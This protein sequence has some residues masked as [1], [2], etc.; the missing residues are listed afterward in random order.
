MSDRMDAMEPPRRLSTIAFVRMGG[1]ISRHGNG[2]LDQIAVHKSFLAQ[3]PLSTLAC[4]RVAE[5]GP[6]GDEGVELAPLT[7]GID[8]R[9]EIR[10][11]SSVEIATGKAGIKL[12]RIDTDETRRESTGDELVCELRCVAAPDRKN[13]LE[14]RS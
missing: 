3:Q 6:I 11:Q 5:D 14:I 4:D 7:A 9:G 13:R 12:R 8:C 10:Q 2:R 1:F